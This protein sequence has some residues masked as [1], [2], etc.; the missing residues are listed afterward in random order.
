LQTG[1]A[2]ST[3]PDKLEI[4]WKLNLKKGIESTAAI[5]KDTV[6]V[7]CYDEHLYAFNLITGEQKWKT[8]LGAIKAPPSVNQDKV[9]VGDED[10]MFYCL[11]ASSGKKLWEFEAGGEISGGGQL[12]RR[13]GPV[14]RP[15]CHPLLPRDQEQGSDLEAQDRRPG[16][17]LRRRRRQ[18]D[19]PGRLR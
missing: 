2:K 7:G 9:F 12:H 11:E 10:G 14:R 18:P 8:K 3:L 1:V 5:V 15:R 6:Y 17:R 4:R 19:V 13:Q 16:V